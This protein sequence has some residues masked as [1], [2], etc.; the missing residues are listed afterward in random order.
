MKNWKKVSAFLV[1]LS[2]SVS[3]ALGFAACGGASDD[4]SSKEGS[5]ITESS[6]QSSA[7]E[8]SSEES[9][10]ENI[11]SNETESSDTESSEP[12]IDDAPVVKTQD[13][14]E[15][16]GFT[17]PA[18]QVAENYEMYAWTEYE[19]VEEPT[20]E[21]AGIKQTHWVDDESVIHQMHIAPRGHNYQ[22]AVCECGDGPVYPQAPANITYVDIE[23]ANTNP[24]ADGSDFK[25]FELTEGYFTASGASRGVKTYW[26]S[27]SVPEPG[28]YALY[29]TGDDAS[30]FTINR[31]DAS[32]QY[33]PVDESGKNYVGFAAKNIDGVLYS[34]VLCETKYW[35]E[36]W[37]AT[38]T[39][40]IPAKQELNFRFVRIDDE[41]WAP[42]TV[43]VAWK[44][45]EINGV[46]AEEGPENCTPTEVPFGTPYFYEESSG[47]YRMGTPENKGEFIYVALTSIPKRMLADKTFALIHY[48]GANLILDTGTTT[49]DGDYLVRDYTPFIS[50]DASANGSAD[51]NCYELYCNSDGLYPVNQELFEFLQLYTKK[52]MPYEWNAEDGAWHSEYYNEN[53]WLAACFYYKNLTPGSK[54]LPHEITAI[55][56]VDVE[57]KEFEF[58]YYNLTYQNDWLQ[59]TITY[60]TITCDD[61]NARI[62]IGDVTTNDPRPLTDGVLVETKQGVTFAISHA[63]GEAATF[64]LHI[65]DAY[66]GSQDDPETLDISKGSQTVA[67][68]TIEHLN[69]SGVANYQKYYTFTIKEDGTLNL[70]SDVA[71]ALVS[72]T[73]VSK[74]VGEDEQE[75]DVSKTV[76]LGEWTPIQV[77]AGTVLEIVVGPASKALDFNLTVEL[78]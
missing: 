28:Q 5:S 78:N 37:R 1:A 72:I 4:N 46:K 55:G 58:V 53:A 47:R 17:Y 25:R 31:Y 27:F 76:M 73:I 57:A 59:S 21:V 9:S 24:G 40:S 49:I 38:Y 65:T 16:D 50:A 7:E 67:M 10:V 62:I 26:L 74:E 15:E 39:V 11:E 33:I 71:N 2:M 51:G 36:N 34:P 66:A 30:A 44:A 13:G 23:T 54:E 14:Y 61:P 6:Q 22:N 45:Q 18:L 19:L 43:R 77:K 3:L 8:N 63:Y 20:C 70:T 29:T 64:T 56:D 48:E 69:P 35:S 68:N 41:P 60:C 12:I 75:Y 52:F 42:Q 32:A